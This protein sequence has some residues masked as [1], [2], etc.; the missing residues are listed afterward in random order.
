MG[1][2]NRIENLVKEGY[3]SPEKMQVPVRGTVWTRALPTYKTPDG[4]LNLVWVG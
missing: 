1:E 4:F 2:E 3:H